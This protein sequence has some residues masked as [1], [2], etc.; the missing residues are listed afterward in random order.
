MNNTSK[1]V[2]NSRPEGIW[3]HVRKFA[4]E[5]AHEGDNENHRPGQRRNLLVHLQIF[6]M[7]SSLVKYLQKNTI[8][9]KPSDKDFYLIRIE[10][11]ITSRYAHVPAHVKMK[12]V[13]NVNIFLN[14]MYQIDSSY[15]AL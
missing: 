4:L 1:W 7:E 11:L 14:D 10:D 5:L 15:T 12:I 8:G 2:L 13:K 9:N 3:N 6:D